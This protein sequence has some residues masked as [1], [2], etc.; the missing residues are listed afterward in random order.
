[1]LFFN[2]LLIVYIS[3]ECYFMLFIVKLGLSC[4]LFL[5]SKLYEDQKEVDLKVVVLIYN[6]VFGV[7]NRGFSVVDGLIL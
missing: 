5:L 6:I 4:F 7:Y 3:I 1:M 2:F